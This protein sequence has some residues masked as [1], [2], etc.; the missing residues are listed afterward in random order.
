MAAI[1]VVSLKESLL[2]AFHYEL[3]RLIFLAEMEAPLELVE[4]KSHI[5]VVMDVVASLVFDVGDLITK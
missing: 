3:K 2:T 4:N 1:I 5:I